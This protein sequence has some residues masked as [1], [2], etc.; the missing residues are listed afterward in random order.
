VVV[1]GV[2]GHA[3]TTS[4]YAGSQRESE[5]GVRSLIVSK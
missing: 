3:Y 4:R 2:A 5:H 1:V